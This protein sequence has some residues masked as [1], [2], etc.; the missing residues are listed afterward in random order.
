[1]I[2][3]DK[4]TGEELILLQKEK[5]KICVSIIVPTHRLSPDRRIDPPEVKRAIDNAKLLMKTNYTESQVKPMF[6]VLDDIYSSIDFDHNQ[7]GIGIFI[8]PDVHLTVKFPFPVEEKVKVSSRF[9]IRDLLY[10]ISYSSSYRVLMLSHK[11]ARM[12]DGSWGELSEISDHSFPA[13]FQDEFIYNPP[14]QSSSYSGYAHVK[15]FEKDK[16]EM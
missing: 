15:S 16:S 6:P 1:M 13:E 14:S 4:L 7:D 8:S 3:E 12:F 5:G 9:E 2:A 10:K 11:E